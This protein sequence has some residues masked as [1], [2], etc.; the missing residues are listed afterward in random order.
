M[1]RSRGD[2]WAKT[3]ELIRGGGS[4]GAVIPTPSLITASTYMMHIIADIKALI[5]SHETRETSV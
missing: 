1:R 4:R 2:K 5:N 3:T